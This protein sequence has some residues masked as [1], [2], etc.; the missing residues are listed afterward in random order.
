VTR[1]SKILE[2]I[3]LGIPGPESDIAMM[4]NSFSSE[5]LIEISPGI[6][7]KDWMALFNMLEQAI[8]T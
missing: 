1:G 3:S 8:P 6:C 5:N 2:K 7:S 4:T